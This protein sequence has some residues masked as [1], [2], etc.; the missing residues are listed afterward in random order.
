MR[1]HTCGDYWFR[2]STQ[3]SGPFFCC[4][5]WFFFIY[6]MCVFIAVVDNEENCFHFFFLGERL[7]SWSSHVPFGV[8][9]RSLS[10][11]YLDCRQSIFSDDYEQLN[12]GATC[13]HK[14]CADVATPNWEIDYFCS[15]L[16]IVAKFQS[17]LN[18]VI[19]A[20]TNLDG[21]DRTHERHWPCVVN[22]KQ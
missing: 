9:D 2:F 14:P 22:V 1:W 21:S 12:C 8:A 19:L 15:Q 17:I 5:L 20:N 11:K 7:R 18:C 6:I 4:S 13:D 16:M 10:R 3:D